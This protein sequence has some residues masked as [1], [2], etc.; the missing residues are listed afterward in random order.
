MNRELRKLIDEY[1]DIKRSLGQI[2]GELIYVRGNDAVV[3]RMHGLIKEYEEKAAACAERIDAA[4]A[5]ATE[6][7]DAT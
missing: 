6:D 1:A 5:L 2:G 7:T 4:L 3:R